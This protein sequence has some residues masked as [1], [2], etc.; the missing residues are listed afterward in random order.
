MSTPLPR[1][2]GV[3]LIELVSVMLI[4]AIIA[5]IAIPRM[6][7]DKSFDV[8]RASNS[9]LADIRLTQLLALSMNESYNIVI[10]SSGQQIF[11][12]SSGAYQHPV[13]GLSATTVPSG[14]SISPQTTVVFS[15]L[16]VPS[17]GG[18]PISS[19]LTFTV[20]NSSESKIITLYAQTG[21]SRES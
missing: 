16:G 10:T 9:L 21:F 1:N 2:Q 5:A 18:V 6:L 4:A 3:T 13:S 15:A 20:A 12:T 19:D 17:V 8:L 14:T 11:S 7:S